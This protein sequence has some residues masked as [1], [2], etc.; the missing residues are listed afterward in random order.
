MKG[1]EFDKPSK[2]SR[3]RI[4]QIPK[5]IGPA[6]E[7]Y[8]KNYIVVTHYC[9][10]E[11]S[12]M[13]WKT[14]S[15]QMIWTRFVLVYNGLLWSGWIKEAK[16]TEKKMQYRAT[17]FVKYIMEGECDIEGATEESKPYEFS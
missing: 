17:Q 12:E 9:L 4:D 13:D 14:N 1:W 11:V 7:Y 8:E 10:V 2:V 15:G 6:P 3:S 5:G 16:L